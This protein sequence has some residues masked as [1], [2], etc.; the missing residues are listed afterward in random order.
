M[1]LVVC[2]VLLPAYLEESEQS[3]TGQREPSEAQ[4]FRAHAPPQGGCENLV[5]GALKLLAN[6]TWETDSWSRFQEQSGSKITN[7]LVRFIERWTT[8]RL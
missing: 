7:E 6:L 1:N 2:S 8:T 5:C 4:V 3:L